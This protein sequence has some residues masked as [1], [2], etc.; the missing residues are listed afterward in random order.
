M[1][2]MKK[3]ILLFLLLTSVFSA[4]AQKNWDIKHFPEGC[5]PDEIGVRLTERY[6]R[7]PHSHW[8]DIDPNRRV[9]LVTYPLT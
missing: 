7:T 5:R 1:N 4:G 6:L 3:S 2:T 8:G 9:T